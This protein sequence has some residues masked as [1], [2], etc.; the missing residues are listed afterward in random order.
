MVGDR[1]GN[2]G[3]V[4][5]GLWPPRKRPGLTVEAQDPTDGC[6]PHSENL[7]NLVVREALLVEPTHDRGAKFLRYRMCDTH[8][9]VRSNYR[10]RVNRP[11]G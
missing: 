4:A 11:L 8:R 9:D 5:T 10:D 1:S 7:G 6:T 2:W 3:E